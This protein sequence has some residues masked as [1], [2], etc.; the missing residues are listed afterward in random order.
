LGRPS[1]AA[2]RYIVLVKNMVSTL[3]ESSKELGW[4]VDGIVGGL[5]DDGKVCF[6]S[7]CSCEYA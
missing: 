5:G 1:P 6:T 3:W 2:F 7:M 4:D